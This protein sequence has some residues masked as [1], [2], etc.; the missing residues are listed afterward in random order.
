MDTIRDGNVF[1]SI[2][3]NDHDGKAMHTV[4]IRRT[5]RDQEGNYHDANT[6][7]GI[8]LLRVSSVA[9]ESYDRVSRLREEMRE[10]A[11]NK[12]QKEHCRT[13]ERDKDRGYER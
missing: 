5:Y 3:E 12:P 13:R 7:T 2:W 9:S 6:Y 11:R 8:D 4:H 10:A 1:A